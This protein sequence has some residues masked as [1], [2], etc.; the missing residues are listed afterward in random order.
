M[1]RACIMSPWGARV[2]TVAIVMAPWFIGQATEADEIDEMALEAEALFRE[3]NARLNTLDGFDRSLEKL[4]EERQA[5]S[6]TLKEREAQVTLVDDRITESRAQL[7]RWHD[8]LKRRLRARSNLNLDDA[9]IR[10]LV[11]GSGSQN[12]WLRRRGYIAAVVRADLKLVQRFHR[13]EAK[14]RELKRLRIVAMDTVHAQR[15]LM[16]VTEGQI[17]REKQVRMIALKRLR[18]KQRV[19]NDKLHQRALERS[20]MSSVNGGS[21]DGFAVQK[22]R[23]PRPV[24]GDLTQSFGPYEHPESGSKHIANGVRYAAVLGTPVFAVYH[25]RVAYAGWFSGFGNLLILD[26]GSGFHTI[27][28]HLDTVHRVVGD[29]VHRGDMIGKVGDSGSLIGPQLYFE[30]REMQIPTDPEPWFLND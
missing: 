24:D 3:E 30:I 27:Y 25:G 12:D 29:R 19:V 15:Q 28:G 23:L 11:L 20:G 16:T 10:R 26:H 5:L 9:V 14:L 4:N 1:A 17:V 18:E 22:G 13:L 7:G 8:R 21:A 2:L 6:S